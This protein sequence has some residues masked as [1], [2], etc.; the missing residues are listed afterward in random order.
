MTDVPYPQYWH[1]E[2]ISKPRRSVMTHDSQTRPDQYDAEQII[3]YMGGQEVIFKAM[4]DYQHVLERMNHEQDMLAR[5][6]PNQWVV[7]GRQ[8]F[9]VVTD[10]LIEARKF[11][12]ENGLKNPDILFRYLDPDP[13]ALI[14]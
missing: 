3:E 9:L 1:M 11:A 2:G 12:E 6:Y 5:K 10:T 4:S 8:G 7:M 13:P 14:L